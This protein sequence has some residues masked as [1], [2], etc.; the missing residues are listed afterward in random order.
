MNEEVKQQIS[1]VV[2][3][4]GRGLRM[5]G[6]DKGLQLFDGRPLIVHVLDRLQPQVASI[7]INA[8]RNLDRYAEF[9]H[10]VHADLIPDFPGPLAGLQLAMSI[11]ATDLVL[12]VPCDTPQLPNDLAARLHAA[13]TATNARVAVAR[14]ADRLHPVFCLAHR[15]CLDHLNS[16]LAAGGRRMDSWYA[17]LTSTQVDFSDQEHAF[18][19]LNTSDE[20]LTAS[21]QHQLTTSLPFGFARSN[22]PSRHWY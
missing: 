6:A 10:P 13:L 5:G 17:G 15:D 11:S 12:S 1:A 16:F 20:L 7:L 2:L 21:G 22:A 4:G 8:N 14:T 3:A 18:H 9:G 19:N